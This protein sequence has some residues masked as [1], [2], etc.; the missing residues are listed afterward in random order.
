MLNCTYAPQ[1]F[2]I[3][4]INLNE[5]MT[6]FI[7]QFLNKNLISWGIDFTGKFAWIEGQWNSTLQKSWMR[8][9]ISKWR[10]V[11]S[12]SS[13]LTN[14]MSQMMLFIY[15]KCPFC[16]F[17]SRL[18]FM[19]ATSKSQMSVFMYLNSKSHEQILCY[20]KQFQSYINT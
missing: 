8:W 16:I 19:F 10:N 9:I 2:Y 1:S 14:A 18:F 3:K 12:I 11:S 17:F 15:V 7:F 20:H 13:K 5:M 6:F 4:F